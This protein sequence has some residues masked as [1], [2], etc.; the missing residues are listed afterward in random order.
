[1]AE[2]RNI[3]V[4]D[5]ET[6]QLFVLKKVLSGGDGERWV[7]TAS[8]AEEALNKVQ[9]TSFDLILT[10]LSMPGMGGVAFTEALRALAP[11]TTVVW[12]TGHGCHRFKREADR[13]DVAA[14]LDKPM[15]MDRIREVVS[16]M[17]TPGRSGTSQDRSMSGNPVG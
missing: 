16:S 9:Q 15:R 13:L 3:L 17:I 1:M 5:D 10:D 11:Q 2:Q 7:E 12:I 8:S 6:R 4:V 14:C